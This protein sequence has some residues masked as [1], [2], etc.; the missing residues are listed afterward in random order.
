MSSS[1]GGSAGSPVVCGGVSVVGVLLGC[2]PLA[3]CLNVTLR[4]GPWVG[5]HTIVSSSSGGCS[6]SCW[7]VGSGV[8]SWIVDDTRVVMCSR[9]CTSSALAVQ[10]WAAIRSGRPLRPQCGQRL[11]LVCCCNGCSTDSS[12][13]DSESFMLRVARSTGSVFQHRP[14]FLRRV[15]VLLSCIS[16]PYSLN[17]LHYSKPLSMVQSIT[18]IVLT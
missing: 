16:I 12:N 7:V 17:T 14:H 18:P 10:S 8:S 6:D 2:H 13:S 5:V 1:V 11:S 9:T 3:V 15:P 4:V